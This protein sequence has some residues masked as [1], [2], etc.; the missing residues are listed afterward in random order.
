MNRYMMSLR[1]NDIVTLY[2]GNKR[3][4]VTIRGKFCNW[5]R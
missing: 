3:F 5:W 4:I 1:I 2:W